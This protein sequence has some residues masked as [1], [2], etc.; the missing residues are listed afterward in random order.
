ML[1][2]IATHMWL[3]LAV[4]PAAVNDDG[5]V[6]RVTS[7]CRERLEDAFRPWIASTKAQQEKDYEQDVINQ[8]QDMFGEGRNDNPLAKLL[9]EQQMIIA[10]LT[11]QEK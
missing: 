11:E 6:C 3:E 4:L 1:D 2:R 9:K 5:E 7:K 8:W 10:G